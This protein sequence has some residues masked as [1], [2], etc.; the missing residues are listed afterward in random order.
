M[1]T[2]VREAMKLGAEAAPLDWP[3]LRFAISLAIYGAALGVTIIFINFLTQFEY[4]EVPQRL[5]V[6]QAL[7]FGGGAAMAGALLCG[8]IAYWMY[9]V[10]PTFSD[11]GRQP[12]RFWVWL[13]I[14]LAYGIFFPLVVG[15]IFLPLGQYFYGFFTSTFSVPDLLVANINLAAPKFLPFAIIN[16]FKLIFTGLEISVPLFG[17]GAWVID[18]FNTSADP[19]TAKYGALAVSISLAV[20]LILFVEFGP[21][22][23]LLKLG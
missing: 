4:F 17:P 19:R 16:G 21:M 3:R 2:T 15:G 22:E 7:L 6:G 1:A 10:R 11:R 23:F 13:S 18:R 9:G 14:G 12:R 8:P 5:P 20:A